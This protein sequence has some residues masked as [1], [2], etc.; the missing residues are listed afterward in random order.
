MSWN[1]KSPKNGSAKDTAEEICDCPRCTVERAGGSKVEGERA[2][3][4]KHKDRII[5]SIEELGFSVATGVA[6]PSQ[7][8]ERE[9]DPFM[10]TIG[11]SQVGIPELMVFGYVPPEIFFDLANRYA[12]DVLGNEIPKDQ[13]FEVTTWFEEQNLPVYLIPV[14]R[15]QLDKVTLQ[16]A[17]VHY[18]GT[19]FEDVAFM[20]IVFKDM[21]RLYP[22]EEGYTGSNDGWKQPVFGTHIKAEQEPTKQ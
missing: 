10:Y 18:E 19:M 20:Q 7:P 22:W 14:D 17:D 12:T 16:M 21:N 8:G 1:S 6:E 3:Y 13:P 9:H 4:E 2:A 15:E 11:L 5:A